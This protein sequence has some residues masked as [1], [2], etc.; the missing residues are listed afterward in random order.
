MSNIPVSIKARGTIVISDGTTIL[1]QNR[2]SLLQK[3]ASLLYV[4]D[5]EG[6]KFYNRC[7]VKQDNAFE[8]DL[9]LEANEEMPITDMLKFTVFCQEGGD[10]FHKLVGCEAH[11]TKTLLENLHKLQQ[12][13]IQTLTTD[14]RDNFSRCYAQI[15][16][17]AVEGVNYYQQVCN[18]ET[19]ARKKCVRESVARNFE[20]IS[21]VK[22]YAKKLEKAIMTENYVQT[23]VGAEMFLRPLSYWQLYDQP[24]LYPLFCSSQHE[25]S[26]YDLEIVVV[27]MQHALKMNHMNP[28]QYASSCED[29]AEVLGNNTRSSKHND[30]SPNGFALDHDT[31]LHILSDFLSTLHV[32]ESIDCYHGDDHC[33][34][35]TLETFS[36]ALRQPNNFKDDCDGKMWA[37]QHL[38]YAV[39]E[40]CIANWPTFSKLF[41]SPNNVFQSMYNN[42]NG[43]Q[44]LDNVFNSHPWLQSCPKNLRLPYFFSVYTLMKQLVD[45]EIGCEA[46]LISCAAQKMGD[47]T[48]KELGGHALSLLSLFEENKMK[49]SLTLEKLLEFTF[50][51]SQKTHGVPKQTCPLEGTAYCSFLNEKEGSQMIRVPMPD[52]NGQL[53]MKEISIDQ[54]ATAAGNHIIQFPTIPGT[55]TRMQRVLAPNAMTRTFYCRVFALGDKLLSTEMSQDNIDANI[56]N[57]QD[58]KRMMKCIANRNQS[59]LSYGVGPVIDLDHKN[60]HEKVISG[61]LTTKEE[62]ANI[63]NFV[64]DQLKE[65]FLPVAEDFKKEMREG[66][67][68]IDKETP[69]TMNWPRK[70]YVC[71]AKMLSVDDRSGLQGEA[72]KQKLEMI[73]VKAKQEA[74]NFNNRMERSK[75]RHRMQAFVTLDTIILNM[76]LFREDLQGFRAAK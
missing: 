1:P 35:K 69:M 57:V 31:K 34:G 4:V 23:D 50:R 60:V 64:K 32:S 53:I 16:W 25:K 46:M 68:G 71:V 37:Q 45:R 52:T 54:F 62:W 63:Q 43:M 26:P 21:A 38:L 20:M 66:M 47:D 41:P 56:S 49:E 65:V 51:I 72:M 48:T 22:T 27:A 11:C 3:R 24:V 67:H 39:R 70:D 30:T 2:A 12:H 13:A 61:K 40:F 18:F 10:T 44:D 8:V 19:A 55:Q 9:T 33:F 28:V 17:K 29:F 75:L 36:G 15:Q 14:V 59:V 58:K 5:Q 73:L 6:S 76:G 42:V 7:E 74:T